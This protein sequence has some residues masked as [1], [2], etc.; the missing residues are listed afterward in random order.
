MNNHTPQDL[1]QLRKDAKLTQWQAAELIYCST[2][3]FKKWELGQR[4]MHP[5]FFELLKIKI[6]KM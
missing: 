5:A 6:G 1:K 2:S 4:E 3:A